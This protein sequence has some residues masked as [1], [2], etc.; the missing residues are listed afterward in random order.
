MLSVFR[1]SVLTLMLMLINIALALAGDCGCPLTKQGDET[2]IYASSQ[3]SMTPYQTAITTTIAGGSR[4][5]RADTFDATT[6]QRT[7][8]YS[9]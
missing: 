9:P 6:M 8:S 4:S 3:G 1:C 5:T 7:G 2:Q